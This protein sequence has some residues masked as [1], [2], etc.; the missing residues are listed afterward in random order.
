[1]IKSNYCL[2]GFDFELFNFL[3]LLGGAS[4][5]LPCRACCGVAGATGPTGATAPTC[6]RNACA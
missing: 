4:S 1:M 2:V 3:L 6:C 5:S